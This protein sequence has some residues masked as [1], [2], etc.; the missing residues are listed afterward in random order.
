MTFLTGPFV[1]LL[2]AAEIM[3]G[4]SGITDVTLEQVRESGSLFKSFDRAAKPYKQLLDIHVAQHFGVERAAEFL[5]LY[6][7][8]ALRA[9]PVKLAK[10]YREVI[11]QAQ[12]STRRSASST[13]ISS[14]PRCSLTLEGRSGKRTPVSTR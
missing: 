5:K 6:G 2:R 9:D 14:S 1:G 8:D 13:G 4:I 10:P 3:R 11:E 12:S 7:A